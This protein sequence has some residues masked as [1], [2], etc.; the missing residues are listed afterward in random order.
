M[1][2]DLIVTQTRLGRKRK[3]DIG[4]A[5]FHSALLLVPFVVEA[6]GRANAVANETEDTHKKRYLETE[7]Q[8]DADLAARHQ[9][10]VD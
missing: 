8:R 4:T 9:H 5:W 6:F 7:Y 3:A 10:D 1:V 2:K